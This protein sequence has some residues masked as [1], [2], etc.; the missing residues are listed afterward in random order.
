M[1]WIA[2]LTGLSDI[3]PMH[4]GELYNSQPLYGKA[5]TSLAKRSEL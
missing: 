3:V 5:L 2:G 4:S 1:T